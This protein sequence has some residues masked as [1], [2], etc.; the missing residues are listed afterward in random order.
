MLGLAR[1]ED[2]GALIR[3]E[4]SKYLYDLFSAE[5]SKLSSLDRWTQRR[6]SDENLAKISLVLEA[7]DPVETCYQN[8][9]R[10][11]DT[12]AEVGIYLAGRRADEPE[13]R[14]LAGDPGISC[15]LALNMTTVAPVVF[16]EEC[17]HSN[18]DLDIVWITIQARF[19]RAKID[20]T[21]SEIIMSH[22]TDDDHHTA[23]MM[24][25][26]RSLLYA[27]HEDLVRRLCKLPS[28]LNEQGTREL[29]LM[30]SE[31]ANRAGDYT[32]RVDAITQRAGTN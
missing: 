4:V 21:I 7:D 23:D 32:D 6:I 8:L 25:S 28:M 11:I 22:L 9:V 26:L 30:I 2:S 17:A 31:L 15:R 19:D 5:D 13:L 12:E 3:D 14:E 27:F 10:E 1:T 18:V 29:V 16:E 24:H 20:A